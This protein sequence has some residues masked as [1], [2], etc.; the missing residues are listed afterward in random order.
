MNIRRSRLPKT[1]DADL[2]AQAQSCIFLTAPGNYEVSEI[3]GDHWLTIEAAAV[4]GGKFS[5]SVSAGLLKNIRH[6]SRSRSN[7][8][9]YTVYG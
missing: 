6:H 5:A 9:V 8:K 2:L 1:L 7:H 3:L 4:Y